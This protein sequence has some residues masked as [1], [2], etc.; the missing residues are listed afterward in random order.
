MVGVDGDPNSLISLQSQMHSFVVWVAAMYSALAV[1]R[2]TSSW[3]HEAQ[4]TAAPCN[5]HY[6]R[7]PDL[8][9]W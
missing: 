9:N 8:G 5:G 2:V 6:N 3:L 1:D 7:M 4:E